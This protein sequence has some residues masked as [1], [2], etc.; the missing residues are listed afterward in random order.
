M[1][2]FIEI[3]KEEENKLLSTKTSWGRN[4]L[5]VVLLEAKNQALI[6]YYV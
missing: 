3:L 1:K 4:D 6:K 5:K 2:R